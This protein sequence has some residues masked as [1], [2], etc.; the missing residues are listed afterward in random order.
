VIETVTRIIDANKQ[1][2]S[3]LKI[4][5]P[6][7]MYHYMLNGKQGVIEVVKGGTDIQGIVKKKGHLIVT[8]SG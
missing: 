4:E 2:K 3:L 8:A 5:P 6:G 1:N 7:E